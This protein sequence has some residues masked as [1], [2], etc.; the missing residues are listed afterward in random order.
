MQR[1][2]YRILDEAEEAIRKLAPNHVSDGLDL[3]V[4]RT[5]QGFVASIAPMMTE[6]VNLPE[7]AEIVHRNPAKLVSLTVGFLCSLV[8]LKRIDEPPKAVTQ[9]TKRVV[10]PTQSLQLR[11]A[12]LERNRTRPTYR[13]YTANA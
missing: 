5:K 10:D 13:L 4:V 6:R 7:K 1:R 2:R 12:F 11:L 8:D 3:Q 9:P